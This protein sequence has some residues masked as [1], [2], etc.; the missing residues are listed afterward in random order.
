MFHHTTEELT[1]DGLQVEEMLQDVPLDGNG[2]FKYTDFVKQ[3][4]SDA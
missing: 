3:F 2:N 4:R 1:P